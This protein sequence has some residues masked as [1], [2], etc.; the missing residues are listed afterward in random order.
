[1]SDK[2]LALIPA[3]GSGTRYSKIKNKLF[4][5]IKK[6]PVII[7]SLIT[8]SS[9][10]L[11]NEI[12]ICAAPEIISH[13]ENLIF[14]YKIK[15]VKKIVSGGK[16]RQESVFNGLLYIKGIGGCDFVVVH[17]GA[18]PLVTTEIL[19]KAIITA[20]DK[21]SCVIGMPV[22]DTIKKI[23]PKTGMIIETPERNL[24]WNIQT[25]Q[26]FRFKELLDAHELLQKETFTDDSALLENLGHSIFTGMGSYKNIKITSEEDLKI[27]EIFLD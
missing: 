19:Q 16:T 11:I 3:A 9:V 26:V 10:S 12:I 8:V 23:N 21:G 17:D 25:P 7:R 24:L 20:K 14:E 4:E 22:K 6:I 5:K 1:L 2:I 27:A 15:K 18:R 13:I